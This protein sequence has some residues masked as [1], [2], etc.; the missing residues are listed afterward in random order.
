[1][2]HIARALQ[3]ALV[4]IIYRVARPLLPKC[5]AC[6]YRMDLAMLVRTMKSEIYFLKFVSNIEG[7]FQQKRLR[8]PYLGVFQNKIHNSSSTMT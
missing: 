2:P 1:M 5:S 3:K 7:Q 8:D 6:G 4:V